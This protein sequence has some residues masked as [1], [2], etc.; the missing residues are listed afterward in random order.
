MRKIFLSLLFLLFSTVAFAQK[1]TISISGKMLDGED[2]LPLPYASIMLYSLP[3]STFLRGTVSD[4]DGNFSISSDIIPGDY[5][6]RMS[7]LGYESIDKKFNVKSEDIHIGRV[8]L[9]MDA[10]LLGEAVVTAEAIPV[11][12]REDT[13]IFSAS[14]FNVADG[15]A[16]EELVKRLPGAEIKDDGKVYVN[17]KEVKR[18][19]VDGKEFFT[20]DPQIALKNLP[21]NMVEKVKTYDR[22]SDNARLT[23]MD[24]DEEETVLD[25]TVK[26]GACRRRK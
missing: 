5:F 15:A 2:H 8:L 18:I 24:D 7:F 10:V 6:L 16:L 22:K 13:T 20:D 26:K 3:D 11:I 4:D 14:A 9:R 1:N 21:A 12:V 25:L 23:G 19:M 17:G